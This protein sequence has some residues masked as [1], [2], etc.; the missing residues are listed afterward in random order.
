M[1]CLHFSPIRGARRCKDCVSLPHLLPAGVGPT[2]RGGQKWGPHRL[3]VGAGV[4]GGAGVQSEH[5]SHQLQLHSAPAG[6]HILLCCGCLHS[7]WHRTLL[8]DQCLHTNCPHTNSIHNHTSFLITSTFHFCAFT[9]CFHFTS[10][11]GFKHYQWQWYYYSDYNYTHQ[12]LIYR[13]IKTFLDNSLVYAM[14]GGVGGTLAV[15][16]MVIVITALLV[17]VVCKTKS[18]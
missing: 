11:H 7:H 15:V 3:Q 8:Q 6:H 13:L 9:R 2:F 17:I 14:A 18:K 10:S 4:G 1:D 16:V 5:H 12:S